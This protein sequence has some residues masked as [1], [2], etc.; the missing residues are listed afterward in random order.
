MGKRNEWIGNY[1]LHY[2]EYVSYK[3]EWIAKTTNLGKCLGNDEARIKAVQFI[4][5]ENLARV[6]KIV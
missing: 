6:V 5:R 3:D 2:T 1:E 4:I